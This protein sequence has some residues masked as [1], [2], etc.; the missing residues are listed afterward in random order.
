M[1]KRFYPRMFHFGLWHHSL[2]TLPAI[3]SQISLRLKESKSMRLL[4]LGHLL[5]T[6]YGQGSEEMSD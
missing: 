4:P 6:L 1:N 3:C 2:L 5:F